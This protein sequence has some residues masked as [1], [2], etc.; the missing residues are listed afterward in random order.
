MLLSPITGIVSLFPYLNITPTS[1]PPKFAFFF[2]ETI[3]FDF[4]QTFYITFEMLSLSEMYTSDL[5]VSLSS[6]Q[7]QSSV[8]LLPAS[9][10]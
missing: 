4:S 3:N 9:G 10:Q 1:N 2:Y 8:Y 6:V 7:E 5:G